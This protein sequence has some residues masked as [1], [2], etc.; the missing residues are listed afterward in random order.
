ML[1][2]NPHRKFNKE[3]SK[4]VKIQIDNSLEL[5]WKKE[6][7]MLATNFPY[8]YRGIKSILVDDDNYCGI[9]D[10]RYCYKVSSHISTIDNL[11]RL[12]ALQKGELYF[13]HDMD[14]YQLEPIIEGELEFGGADMALTDYGWS[15]KWNL[16][17]IFFKESARDLF[18]LLKKT[19]YDNN[20]ADER[21]FRMLIN[22][23]II[24]THRYKKLNITYNL[25]M[26]HVGQIYRMADKPIKIIHF[27]PMYRD[28]NMPDTTMNIFWHGRNEAKKVLMTDRLK[29]I[30]EKYGFDDNYGIKASYGDF[31]DS[32]S[33]E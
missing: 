3:K 6:D 17:V 32:I 22:K 9:D 15:K 24:P 19:I 14:A 16:G 10:K 21:S 33:Y 18:S 25:G 8:E 20:L 29:R 11:F 23:K 2:V 28:P 26:R 27:H 13:Y 4:L 12:G 5:G 1:N 30:F 7:L 31:L